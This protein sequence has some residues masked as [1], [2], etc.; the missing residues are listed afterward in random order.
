M[1]H[2]RT[3]TRSLLDAHGLA[4][5]RERGQNFVTDPNT[6]RRIAQ[7]ARL[8][9]SDLVVEIGAGLGALTLALAE[10]GA[11]VVAVEVDHGLCRV[12]EDLVGGHANVS[13]VEADATVLDWDSLIAPH[14]SAVVVANLPYNIATTLVVDILDHVTAVERMVVMVQRE[15]AERFVARPGSKAYGA[16][17]VRIAYWAT[18]RIVGDVPASVFLPRPKVDSALVEITRRP[19]PP[20]DRRHLA[21]VLRVGF[22][23]RRKMLRRSLAAIADETVFAAAGV[24]PTERP[25]DLDLDAWCRLT[26]AVVDRD[27]VLDRHDTDTHDTDTDTDIDDTTRGG[28]DR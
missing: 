20:V 24:A 15:V 9:P 7:L 4:P 6:V 22:G 5:R 18:A 23:Q 3:T 21:A 17:S 8:G 25:E 14:H 26:T 16:I 13:V 28:L 1:T 19:P 10:T 2:S 12:L 11:S 27:D